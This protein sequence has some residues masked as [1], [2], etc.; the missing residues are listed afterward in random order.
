MLI[1][2]T[3]RIRSPRLML[4]GDAEKKKQLFLTE[5]DK[6]VLAIVKASLSGSF[7][8]FFL[9]F[10]PLLIVLALLGPYD[11]LLRSSIVL[12]RA[13]SLFAHKRTHTLST[14]TTADPCTT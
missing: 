9:P 10:T 8:F 3:K 6:E 5:E 14:Q 11:N 7:P 13:R 4:C 2:Q 12:L 1:S